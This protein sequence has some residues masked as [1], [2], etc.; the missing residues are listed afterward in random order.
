M[1][2]DEI[3]TIFMAEAAKGG[4]IENIVIRTVRTASMLERKR[5]NEEVTQTLND[6]AML[7]LKGT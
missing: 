3:I 5:Q 6:L 1:T 2:N 7:V 4:H